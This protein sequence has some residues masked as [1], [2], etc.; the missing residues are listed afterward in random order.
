MCVGGL[1]LPK[2]ELRST[3]VWIPNENDI[4]VAAPINSLP[5]G[6]PTCINCLLYGKIGLSWSSCAG[7]WYVK[8]APAV[9]L[10]AAF[11]HVILDIGILSQPLN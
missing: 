4:Q 6:G 5:R 2:Y 3:R 8:L 9:Y 1:K 10:L 7:N 11:M